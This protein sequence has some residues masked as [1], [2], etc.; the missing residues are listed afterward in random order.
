MFK[1]E[2]Y[3]SVFSIP[4]INTLQDV[5]KET[6]HPAERDRETEINVNSGV[7]SSHPLLKAGVL[8]AGKRCNVSL[9]TI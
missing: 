7:R 2:I 5:F 1:I 4:V 3:L 8:F 9:Q 6:L